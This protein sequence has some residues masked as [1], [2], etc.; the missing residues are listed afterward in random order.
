MTIDLTQGEKM[1]IENLH[2][3]ETG[4]YESTVLVS[5]YKDDV[6]LLIGRYSANYIKYGTEVENDLSIV[7]SITPEYF[8]YRLTG[9]CEDPGL[10]DYDI[11]GLQKKRTIIYGELQQVDYYSNYDG[12]TYENLAVKEQRRYWRDAITGL[13]K[14]RELEIDWYNFNEVSIK[15][16]HFKK[17]Y[18]PEESIAEGID[19]RTNIINSTKSLA[20]AYLGLNYSFDL[21][22]SVKTQIDYFINGYTQPLRD[23]ITNSTKPYLTPTMK[24]NLVDNMAMTNMYTI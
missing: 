12:F 20:V 2:V 11:L 1:L 10:I 6:N 9:K 8:F 17:F 24:T 22:T 13:V 16:E 7:R 3:C 19:R 4:T 23:A 5:V 14:F 15:N 18:S 21:L